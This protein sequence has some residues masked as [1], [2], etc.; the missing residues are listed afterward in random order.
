MAREGFRDETI[1]KVKASIGDGHVHVKWALSQMEAKR[2]AL[3]AGAKRALEAQGRIVSGD[4]GFVEAI[5]EALI[6]SATTPLICVANAFRLFMSIRQASSP[7]IWCS[8]P[9]ISPLKF[10]E[11]VIAL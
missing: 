1:A 10:V 8:A 9:I 7:M 4:L 2:A 3:A 5:G 11:S 6:V